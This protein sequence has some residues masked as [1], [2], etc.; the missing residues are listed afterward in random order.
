MIDKE[1]MISPIDALLSQLFFLWVACFAFTF[2]L[3]T[4]LFT[5][6]KYQYRFLSS[7]SQKSIDAFFE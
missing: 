6:S 1:Q 7:F 3:S 2:A 5:S 4:Y